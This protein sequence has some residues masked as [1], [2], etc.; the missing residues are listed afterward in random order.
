MNSRPA[1][2]GPVARGSAGKHPMR[3][4]GE[5]FGWLWGPSEAERN[6]RNGISNNGVGQGQRFVQVPM[7]RQQM[8]EQ[9]IEDG[10][11]VLRR[12]TIEEIEIRREVPLGNTQGSR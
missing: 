10:R 5:F 7:Q 1:Q 11:I 6:R 3:A 9:R 8:V 12:T 2:Q 4:A